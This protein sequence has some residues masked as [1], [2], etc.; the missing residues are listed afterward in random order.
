MP[1]T[2]FEMAA[3]R[4]W[5]MT[6]DALDTLMV[7]ADRQGDI[8]ALETRLGRSLDNTRNVTVRDGVAVIPVTGPIFRHANL[9]TEISGA[10]STGTLATDIQT[11]LDDPAV[12]ALVLDID[13]PGGEAT[14]INEMSDLIFNARGQKPIK[15]YASGTTASAAYWIASAAD[16]VVV[17]DTAQLGS[18]GV[19]MTLQKQPERAGEKTWEIVSSN[20]PNKRPDPDTQVGLE[21][22]QTRTDEIANV[23]LDKVARN[24]GIDRSEVNDRFRQGGIATGAHAVEA[25]M[26]DRLGSLEGLVS[27]LANTPATP[28]NQR[29]V[30][31]TTV[32]TTAELHAAIDAGTDPKT[33]TL[34]EPEAVDK[35][36]IKSNAAV[37]ATASER[38]RCKGLMDLSAPGFEKDIAAAIDDGT[39]VEAAGL[40]MFK[41]AQERGITVQGIQQDATQTASTTPSSASAEDQQHKQGVEAIT[42][43]FGK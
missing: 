34:A 6:A 22:L 5:L 3:S 31:M 25:G 27:E 12:R 2:A 29:N 32:S 20:A 40:Q 15:A 26:A 7:V 11:A 10:T 24:R 18:V 35:D 41:A 33:L 17:D 39:S 43:F 19:V 37:E 42:G 38:A 4:C 9:L 1:R 28:R 30:A 23:F 8:E 36:K 16:E 13:S 14:G 21:Q